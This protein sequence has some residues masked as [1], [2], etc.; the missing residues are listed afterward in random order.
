VYIYIYILCKFYERKYIFRF[1][2]ELGSRTAY[3]VKLHSSNI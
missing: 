1:Q 3:F 2:L